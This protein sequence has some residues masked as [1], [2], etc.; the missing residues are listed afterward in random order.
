LQN[1]KGSQAMDLQ[2]LQGSQAIDLQTL[3]GLQAAE[4]QQDKTKADI[5]AKYGDWVTTMATAPGADQQAWQNMLDMLTGAG[6]WPRP[7]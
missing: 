3:T 7:T 4:I 2:N 5:W 1:I 6:G